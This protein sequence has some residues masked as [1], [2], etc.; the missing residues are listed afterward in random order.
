M[1]PYDTEAD[2]SY[3][4]SLFNNEDEC[5]ESFLYVDHIYESDEFFIKPS[6]SEIVDKCKKLGYKYFEITKTKYVTDRFCIEE[7]V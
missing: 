5:E 6:I 3:H 2:T 4:Y 1:K 7:E